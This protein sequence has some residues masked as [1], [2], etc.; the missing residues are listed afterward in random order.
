MEEYQEPEKK[1]ESLIERISDN[2]W[3]KAL[4]FIGVWVVVG[5]IG[6]ALSDALFR[7]VQ[8]AL[9]AGH[10]LSWVAGFIVALSAWNHKY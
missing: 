6:S 4:V 2:T 8:T 7:E 3:V 9:D 10:I 5:V 1:K